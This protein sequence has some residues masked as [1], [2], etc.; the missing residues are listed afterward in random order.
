MRVITVESP[1]GHYEVPLGTRILWDTATPPTNWQFDTDLTSVFVMGADEPDLTARGAIN[2]THTTPGLA[3]GGAHT[4][5]SVTIS[6]VSQVTA[7]TAISW[8]YTYNSVGSHS[9]SGSGSVSSAGAHT[10]TTPNTGTGSNYP[11]F[12]KLRWIYS[13]TSTVVPV[14]GIVMHNGSATALGSGWQVCDGTNGTYDMRGYF[15]IHTATDAEIGQTGGFSSHAHAVGTSGT[16]SDTH[17]HSVSIILSTVS[18]QTNSHY[19]TDA[20]VQDAHNHTG[21]GNTP[22]AGSHTHSMNKTGSADSLPPYIQLYFIKRI[23]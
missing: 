17:Q 4:D 7:T 21:S 19:T 20:S 3:S 22:S 13:N 14:G 5:H 23:A 12:R 2:H 18:G 10:H 11:P 16:A 8:S 6:N 1:Q 15:P 9:H